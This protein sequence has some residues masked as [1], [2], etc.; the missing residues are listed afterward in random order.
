MFPIL[1]LCLILGLIACVLAV[2]VNDA[3]GITPRAI[4]ST[5]HIITMGL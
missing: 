3:F 2:P 1:R 4:D 5:K